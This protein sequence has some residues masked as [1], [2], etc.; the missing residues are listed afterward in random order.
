MALEILTTE[1]A[2]T[3]RRIVIKYGILSR[4]VE[5]APLDKIQNISLR[6]GVL[7]RLVNYGT[8]VVQTAATFG[9]DTFPYVR[10]PIKFRKCVSEQI[11]LYKENQIGKQA[12]A[13]AR[14][15]NK[16]KA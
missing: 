8:I 11:D 5:E 13:L 2:I 6:Q 7:G 14:E 12:E 9:R 15:I 10:N 1:F 16:G 3:T 4:N